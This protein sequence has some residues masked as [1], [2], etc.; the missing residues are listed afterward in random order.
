MKL[1]VDVRC[2]AKPKIKFTVAGGEM[3]IKVPVALDGAMRDRIA[4][5][6]AQVAI[7]CC[8]VEDRHTFRGNVGMNEEGSMEVSMYDRHTTVYVREEK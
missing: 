6:A 5:F 7:A 3:R 1:K 4:A 8:K 2:Y